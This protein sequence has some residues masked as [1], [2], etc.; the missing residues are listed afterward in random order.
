MGCVAASRASRPRDDGRRT[1]AAPTLQCSLPPDAQKRSCAQVSCY[2][3][4]LPLLL[5]LLAVKFVSC[6]L[7]GLTLAYL[8][9]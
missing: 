8:L 6:E 3:A 7:A 5:L 9:P 4:N 2:W 1:A